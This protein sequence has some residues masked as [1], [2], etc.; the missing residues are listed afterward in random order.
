MGVRSIELSKATFHAWGY[1]ANVASSIACSRRQCSK[2]PRLGQCSKN[3]RLAKVTPL[4]WMR[5][6]SV[7]ENFIVLLFWCACVCFWFYEKGFFH[8]LF[9]FVCYPPFLS[10]LTTAAY[11]I[12]LFF[13]W[14]FVPSSLL[15][16][17]KEGWYDGGSISFAVILVIFVTGNCLMFLIIF[18]FKFA[19]LM[20][21]KWRGKNRQM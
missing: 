5:L 13:D 17:L 19:I 14:R 4:E 10:K 8:L 20:W 21:M 3:S 2:N 11:P 12:W 9:C 18:P 6:T 1:R 15:Q 16:G 7:Y